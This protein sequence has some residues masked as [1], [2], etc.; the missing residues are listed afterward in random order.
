MWNFALSPF[1][2]ATAVQATPQKGLDW[3]WDR[4]TP[5]CSL[6]QAVSADGRI[7]AISRTPGNDST[8]VYL[9]GVTPLVDRQQA[10]PEGKIIFHPG[11]SSESTIYVTARGGKRDILA[12]SD[13]SEFLAKL[14]DATELE[15]SQQKLATVRVPLRSA[16]AAVVAM[17][18][19][20]DFRMR[21][22]GIDPVAWH[23]LSV[24][25]QPVK[26][27]PSWFTVDDYPIGAVLEGLQGYS[28]SRVEVAPDGRVS[29]CVSLNRNRRANARDRMCDKLKRRARFTPAR[30][31]SG[32]AVAAPYVVLVKFQIA[33]Q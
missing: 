28:I 27:S 4:T 33:Y 9:G 14:A 12:G 26:N 25:P 24:R 32:T 30:D 5:S 3:T 11:G 7:V 29:N 21:D 22:W 13:D 15:L 10:F 17:R 16:S 23:S 18:Q 20:E 6:Q 2:L 1:L 31:A 8:A 19:C